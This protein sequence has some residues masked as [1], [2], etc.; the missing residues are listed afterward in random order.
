MIRLLF[1]LFDVLTALVFARD[2]RRVAEL[3]DL[4]VELTEAPVAVA[5]CISPVTCATVG[6]QK[7]CAR[8]AEAVTP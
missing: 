6:C 8:A 7:L 3:R 4:C 5:G 1:R 2:E